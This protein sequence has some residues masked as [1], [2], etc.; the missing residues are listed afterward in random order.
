MKKQTIKASNIESAMKELEGIKKGLA[1]SVSQ[2]IPHA[3][4]KHV[5]VAMVKIV[6][7]PGEVENEVKVDTVCYDPK[8]FERM[9]KRF[10]FHGYTKMIV[11]HDP[12]QIED[13]GDAPVV[14]LHEKRKTEAEI[15]AEV[16]AEMDLEVEKRVAQ[17][18]KE[19]AEQNKGGDGTEGTGTDGDDDDKDGP[20]PIDVKVLDGMK[21]QELQDFAKE[22]GID[23]SGLNNK[24]EYKVAITTWISEYN[25]SIQK[26]D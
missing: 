14:P 5:V 1:D 22:K 15:R 18:L 24:E 25:E 7:K 2:E 17:K 19:K 20:Q 21:S 6:D 13:E 4:R 10:Q 9:K 16:Q 26:E 23:L 11:L 12:S 8:R 3:N